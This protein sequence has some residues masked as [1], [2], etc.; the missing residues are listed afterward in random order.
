VKRLAA[1]LLAALFLT[2]CS[3]GT[4]ST[5]STVVDTTVAPSDAPTTSVPAPTTTDKTSTVTGTQRALALASVNGTT[6]AAIN[7]NDSMLQRGGWAAKPATTDSTPDTVAAKRSTREAG[8]LISSLQGSP[9]KGY[10]IT[11]YGSD[12]IVTVF[13][14][15]I[16]ANKELTGLVE[17]VEVT[18]KN[19]SVCLRPSIDGNKDAAQIAVS[20]D[21]YRDLPIGKL[22]RPAG[23]DGWIVLLRTTDKGACRLALETLGTP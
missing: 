3:A 5:D 17:Y 14:G 23:D 9:P 16:I 7:L 20:N 10:T 1:P 11:T 8:V 13:N 6:L 18:S 21:G 2:A 4:A 19:A 22:V 15:A 12:G